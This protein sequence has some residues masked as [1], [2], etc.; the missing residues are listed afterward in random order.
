MDSVRPTETHDPREIGQ[1]ANDLDVTM[2]NNNDQSDSLDPTGGGEYSS[3]GGDQVLEEE[4]ED[5]LGKL[6][7]TRE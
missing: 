4:A 5:E 7:V 1:S 3:L 6:V 2:T